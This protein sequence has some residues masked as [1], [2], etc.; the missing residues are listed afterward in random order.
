MVV[1]TASRTKMCCGPGAGL[2][3]AVVCVGSFR[4]TRQMAEAVGPAQGVGDSGALANTMSGL[5]P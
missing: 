3:G 1:E 4:V 5:P 2:D